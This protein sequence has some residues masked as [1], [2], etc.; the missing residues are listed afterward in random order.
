M[1]RIQLEEYKK[2]SEMCPIRVCV[3][4]V[5]SCHFVW[6]GLVWCGFCSDLRSFLFFS[7]FFFFLN[8]LLLLLVFSCCW[9]ISYYLLSFVSALTLSFVV[10]AVEMSSNI[11]SNIFC[12]PKFVCTDLLLLRLFMLTKIISRLTWLF[13][14]A[15]SRP[16]SSKIFD[17]I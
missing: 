12:H 3:F 15:L 5:H 17:Q 10:H 8:A 7:C 14:G 4:T 16:Q 9:F 1:H 2:N 11:Q 6:F 13:A